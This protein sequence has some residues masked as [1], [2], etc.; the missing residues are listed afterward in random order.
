MRIDSRGAFRFHRTMRLLVLLLSFVSAACAA[1]PPALTAALENF[2]ADA[3]KGWSFTQTTTGEGKSTV[4][5]SDAA[6]PE[7]DRWT[8]VQKDGRT[9]T[10][11]ETKDYNEI[12][13]RRSRGGTAPKL[14]DQF[15]LTTA[16]L[17]TDAPDRATYR[18]RMKRG[19]AGDL[20]AAFLRVTVVIHKATHTIESIEL[21][22]AEP[23]KPALGV[24]IAE[25]ATKMTYSVPT[26][27]RPSLPLAVT[28]HVR[29]TAFIFK[30]LDADMTVAF[31][32]YERV[33][34]R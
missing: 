32:D 1:V 22:S 6:K 26:G 8:L 34:K 9:P 30:S 24:K 15:D 23:F 16:E 5:R 29:G 17:V 13:S 7:F 25:L 18:L 20:T 4:E 21:T 11:D 3:P 2:R 19:E 33:G 12:R 14:T 27:D 10:A 31:T 28:T